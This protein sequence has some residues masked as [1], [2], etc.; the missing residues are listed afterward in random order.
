MMD[1]GEVARHTGLRASA[2]RHYESLGLIRSASRH[3]LRR[4][5]ADDV[6]D[7]L[8]FIAL[9]QSVGLSLDEIGQMLGADGTLSVDRSLLRARADEFSR[10][11]RRLTA[12]RDGL[13]HAADC[14]AQHHLA[15]PTFQRLIRGVRQRTSRSPSATSGR[16]RPVTRD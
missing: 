2:L 13:R 9:G 1:I 3:G 6:L 11:I 7:R 8:A 10:Q 16:T 14:R 15:C 5:F 4:Q 12:M